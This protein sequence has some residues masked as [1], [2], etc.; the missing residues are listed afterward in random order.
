MK[1]FIDKKECNKECNLYR[2]GFRF[3]DD[4]TEPKPFEA[5][6]FNIMTD[7]LEQMITRTIGVQKEMNE[8]RSATQ[9]MSEIMITALK[10]KVKARLVDA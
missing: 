7:C 4:G 5:C 9:S 6:S 1:C 10:G 2:V 3:K 8:V